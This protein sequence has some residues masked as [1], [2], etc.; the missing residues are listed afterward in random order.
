MKRSNEQSLSTVLGGLVDAYGMREKMDE[1]DISTAW[2]NLVG[3]MIAR[4]TIRLR[5]KRGKLFIKVDSAP[6]RHELTFQ[7]EGLTALINQRLE[8][9]VVKEVVIE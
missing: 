6:L 2:D 7:R 8:R 9:E 3:G 4:H 1:L 5:L